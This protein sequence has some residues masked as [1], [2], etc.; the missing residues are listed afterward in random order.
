M[1]EQTT[2]DAGEGA[3]HGAGRQRWRCWILAEADTLAVFGAFGNTVVS[4][5]NR[6]AAGD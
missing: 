6:I 2:F 5:P 4:E 1:A 3:G